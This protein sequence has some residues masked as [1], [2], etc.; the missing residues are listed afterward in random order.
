M[1]GR[2]VVR[3]RKRRE[4]RGWKSENGNWPR[5]LRYGGRV[6]FIKTK[7]LAK[8]RPPTRSERAGKPQEGWAIQWR[9][10]ADKETNAE[11]ESLAYLLINWEKPHRH[12]RFFHV[13]RRAGSG[14]NICTF[15]QCGRSTWI[16]QTG[17]EEKR[18]FSLRRP[19]ASRERSGKKKSAC[20]ARN[21]GGG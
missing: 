5:S 15:P 12:L 7:R 14:L 3:Q 10:W 21:D 13:T 2:T 1:I 8:G 6:K 19:T 16:R 11:R 18:D 4:N 17:C 9:F 20:S